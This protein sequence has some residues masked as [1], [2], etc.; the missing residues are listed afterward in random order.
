[1]DLGKLSVSMGVV[2]ESQEDKWMMLVG[3]RSLKYVR[4]NF[5]EKE[6]PFHELRINNNAF[7]PSSGSR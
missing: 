1:M 4:I 2:S 6:N 5:R 7:K 3:G